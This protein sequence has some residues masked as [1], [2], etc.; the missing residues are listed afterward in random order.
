MTNHEFDDVD[1]EGED[2]PVIEQSDPLTPEDAADVASQDSEIDF[3]DEVDDEV[4]SIDVVE[5][6]EADALLDDPEK[7]EEDE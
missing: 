4:G 1:D 5:A 6:I 3:D 2:I 7:L